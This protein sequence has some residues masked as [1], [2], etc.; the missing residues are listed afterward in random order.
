MPSQRM[1]LPPIDAYNPDVH[2]QKIEKHFGAARGWRLTP[3]LEAA[4]D[5]L[6]CFYLVAFTNRCGSNYVAQCMGS[7]K[8]LR[9]AQEQLNHDVVIKQSAKHGLKSYADYLEWVVRQRRDANGYFGCKAGVGQLIG[10]HAAG[11]LGRVRDRLRIV[12]VCRDDIVDQAVSMFIARR[13]LKWTSAHDGQE[14][15]IAYDGAEIFRI[16]EV[17]SY[18]RALFQLLFRLL[19]VEPITIVYEEFVAKPRQGVR[20]IGR[21]LGLDDLRLAANAVTYEKQANETN[22]KLKERFLEDFRLPAP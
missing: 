15:D 5:G 11:V 17:V 8:L 10:L 12:Y 13:T 21:Y 7:G 20:R 18:E 16:A 2:R 1:Q 22:R 19:D 3:G 4:L 6:S 14:A 9:Q